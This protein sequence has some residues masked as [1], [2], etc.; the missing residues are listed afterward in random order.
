[1]GVQCAS[2]RAGLGRK[3]NVLKLGRGALTG[4]GRGAD[5]AVVIVSENV[6]GGGE[7][8]GVRIGGEGAS[9]GVS[10][11]SE[12]GAGDTE[13]GLSRRE[14]PRRGAFSQ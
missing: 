8:I 1:M 13:G 3:K 12:V 14:A 11:G 7:V 2:R 4:T 10:G 6:E 5:E 9:R